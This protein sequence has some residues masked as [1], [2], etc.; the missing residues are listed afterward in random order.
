V[1][2]T[3]LQITDLHLLPEPGA[4]LLGVDT[5]ASLEAVLAQAFSERRPDAVIASG[6][7]THHGD[8]ATYMRF[9]ELL[10]RYHAGPLLLLPGNHDESEAMSGFLEPAPTLT[11][12][13][14]SIVGFD[15]HVDGR[16]EAVVSPAERAA[17]EAACERAAQLGRHVLLA[18]HH[19]PIDVGCPWLDKD[20]IQDGP[21][22]LESLAEH[23]T[24]VAMV[25]GHAHQVIEEQR[26][27]LRLLG[28]PSTCFQFL[29]H[30][31]SFSIDPAKP[32]YRWLLL[33]EEGAVTSEVRRVEDYPL[34]LELPA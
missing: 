32:G 4:R 34:E 5:Q 19:P 13:A 24:V 30:S 9:V 1:P 33:H 15:S 23:T 10:R 11:L 6:D 21:E 12:G 17:L 22:L 31:E 29:P 27:G 16:P 2:L 20:R 14:W 3:V 25:F 8:A 26:H 28:T 18:T 7:I